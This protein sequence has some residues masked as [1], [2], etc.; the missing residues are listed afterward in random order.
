MEDGQRI[1]AFYTKEQRA[2]GSCLFMDANGCCNYAHM[3]KVGKIDTEGEKKE[4]AI[5]RVYGNG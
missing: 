5:S 2:D 4:G 3:D 1:Y